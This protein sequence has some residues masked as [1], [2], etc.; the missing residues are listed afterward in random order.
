MGFRSQGLRARSEKMTLKERQIERS[1]SKIKKK[2]VSVVMT[3]F[4]SM[5]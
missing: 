5:M 4:N 1:S 3:I 2:Y